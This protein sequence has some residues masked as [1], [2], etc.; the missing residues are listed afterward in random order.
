MK[1]CICVR[2]RPVSVKEVAKN[3]HDSVTCCNP[4]VVV[5]DC[6][7]RVDG[8]TKYLDNNS[9]RLDHVFHEVRVRLAPVLH[10]AGH[11]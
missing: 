9:F 5:H 6:K 8:I 3:D 11:V 1:I 10:R 2:K 4:V 7:L